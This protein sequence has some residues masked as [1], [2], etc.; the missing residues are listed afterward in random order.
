MSLNKS[1]IFLLLMSLTS[2]SMGFECKNIE[3]LEFAKELI[4]LDLSGAR[5]DNYE[6]SHCLKKENYKH[7]V[8]VY[9]PAEDDINN[10]QY[11]V[12]DFKQVKMNKPTFV[13]K[14][15]FVYEVKYSYSG[16]DQKTKKKK[17]IQDSIRFFLNKSENSQKTMGCASL[18]QAPQVKSILKNCIVQ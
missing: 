18:I 2:L 3:P 10:A 1:L 6:D 5:L 9:S 17:A 4:R 12:E 8:T 15:N 14:D 13:D 11:I 7:I 16:T